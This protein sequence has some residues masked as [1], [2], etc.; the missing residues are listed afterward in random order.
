VPV[1]PGWVGSII[2]GKRIASEA[3]DLTERRAYPRVARKPSTV[4][5]L[6]GGEGDGWR[7]YRGNARREGKEA[8]ERAGQQR[9]GKT[10]GQRPKSKPNLS[11]LIFNVLLIAP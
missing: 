9:P 11:T 10:S 3:A 6:R 4:S 1:L 5:R 8:A 7:A 2:G